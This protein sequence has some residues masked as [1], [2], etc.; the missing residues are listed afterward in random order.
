MAAHAG[1]QRLSWLR[2]SSHPQAQRIR[3]K[4]GSQL[5]AA[6]TYPQFAQAI[7]AEDYTALEM[8]FVLAGISE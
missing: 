5:D 1:G 8:A 3:D 7:S 6:S 2:T 4:Y